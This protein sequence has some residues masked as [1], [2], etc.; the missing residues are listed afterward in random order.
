[1][2]MYVLICFGLSCCRQKKRLLICHFYGE[3]VENQTDVRQLSIILWP[4]K[5]ELNDDVSGS[6]M[7]TWLQGQWE[8]GNWINLRLK[9]PQTSLIVLIFY[10]KNWPTS[11]PLNTSPIQ[12]KDTEHNYCH[13]KTWSLSTLFIYFSYNFSF[14]FLFMP[15]LCVY[16]QK[17]CQVV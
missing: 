2:M 15:L 17:C 12:S 8:A 3:V 9:P 13:T 14:L 11:T 16:I 4:K 7:F 6:K 1:M 5:H 10:F